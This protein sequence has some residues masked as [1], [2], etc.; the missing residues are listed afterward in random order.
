MTTSRL[1][2]R[3]ELTE[4]EAKPLLHKLTLVGSVGA[5]EVQP[6]DN[7]PPAQTKKTAKK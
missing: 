3:F 2:R 5:V 1:V 6:V 7:E 4:R